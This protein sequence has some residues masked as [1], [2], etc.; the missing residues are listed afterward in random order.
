[1]PAGGW[2]ID[3]DAELGGTVAPVDPPIR[4][5]LPTSQRGAPGDGERWTVRGYDKAFGRR[6]PALF[7]R[8]GLEDVRHEAATQVV[9]EG[10][11]GRPGGA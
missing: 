3:E 11:R 10:Q 9:R 7:E 2:L 1:V 5:L 8:C 6:P 4:C